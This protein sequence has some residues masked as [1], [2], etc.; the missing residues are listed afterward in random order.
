MSTAAET[1]LKDQGSFNTASVRKASSWVFGGYVS[2]QFLRL[3]SNLILT[4]LLA[5]EMFGL[6][7]IANVVIA[8]VQMLSDMGIQK[9]IIQSKKGTDTKYL[10]TAWIL[11]IARGI[12]LA[13]IVSG[14]SVAVWLAAPSFSP[15]SVYAHPDLPLVLLILASSLVISGFRTTKSAVANRQLDMGKIT[16]IELSGQIVS[17]VVMVVWAAYWPNVWALV[18]G[19]VTS[20][21]YR[22]C[23][24]YFLL[25][26]HQN[27]F[28]FDLEFA[29]EIFHFGKWIFAT[30][31]LGYWVLNG[32]R[33][34][35]GFDISA[36]EMG[37]YSI[38]VFIVSSLRGAINSLMQK[39][40][41]PAMSRALR[42]NEDCVAIYYRF[43]LPLDLLLCSLS[44]FLFIAGEK[45]IKILY[46]DRYIAAGVFLSF[47]SLGLLAD[48]YRGLGLYYQAQGQPKK[49]MPI[50]LSRAVLLTVGLPLALYK[51]DFFGAVVFLGVY[52][53]MVVPLQLYLKTR[54]GLINV[55]REIA[56]TAF[57]IPGVFAGYCFLWAVQTL[58]N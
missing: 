21:V 20:S 15:D 35:L 29:K 19:T 53:I 51:Y 57:I 36:Y 52:P 12:S 30:S 17:I 31:L 11:Q 18:A 45:V 50:A 33:L 46:D 47:L 27:R 55:S 8:G 28:R 7:A 32:D 44:G 9:N 2:A 58:N 49:M 40:M 37:V 22:I 24:E 54:A 38:A 43:R 39:V 13:A 23:I 5:P 14:L 1:S 26:G 10:D 4:R 41:Y 6:M 42:E 48:R 34:I 56:Y 25:P 3:F 16:A